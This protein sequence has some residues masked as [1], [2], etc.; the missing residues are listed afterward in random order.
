MT[1][2]GKNH[3]HK[4]NTE[5]SLAITHLKAFALEPRTYRQALGDDSWRS[6]MSKEYNGQLKKRTWDLIQRPPTQNV[7]G[8]RWVFKTKILPSGDLD[9]YKA[10]LVAQGYHQEYGLDYKETFSPAVKVVTILH[11]ESHHWPIRQ[12]DVNQAFL[13]GNLK[14]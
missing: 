10:R 14:E 12:P 11:A 3:I 7:V 5:Y 2:R 13:Q 4:P 9:K 8:C 6:A 1:T